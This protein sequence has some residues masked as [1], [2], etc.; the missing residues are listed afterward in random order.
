MKVLGA[1]NECD[2]QSLMVFSVFG[3]PLNCGKAFFEAVF[4]MYPRVCCWGC[5][6]NC[7]S[8][9]VYAVGYE[10]VFKLWF[11]AVCEDCYFAVENVFYFSRN[12]RESAFKE[13]V[14]IHVGANIGYVESVVLE[15]SENVFDGG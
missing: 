1:N 14:A 5:G 3:K 8:N 4:A 6:G 9:L 2:E 11:C 7:D 10:S 12:F 13:G 15:V